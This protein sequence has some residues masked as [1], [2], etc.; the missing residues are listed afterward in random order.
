MLKK[1]YI[2]FGI[3]CALLLSGC[4]NEEIKKG[5]TISVAPVIEKTKNLDYY[6]KYKDS[7]NVC[8]IAQQDD[9]EYFAIATSL[10]ICPSEEN[11]NEHGLKYKKTM[12]EYRP[13]NIDGSCGFAHLIHGENKV[14]QQELASLQE[15]LGDLDNIEIHA[16][17]KCPTISELSNTIVKDT[18]LRFTY[19]Y[20]NINT[21]NYQ[22]IN[23]DEFRNVVS[24]DFLSNEDVS[25]I[26]D[27]GNTEDGE[28]NLIPKILETNTAKD[29]CSGDFKN[30]V[31]D[32]EDFKITNIYNHQEYFITTNNGYKLP[33]FMVTKGAFSVCEGD[34]TR[35]DFYPNEEILNQGY[36]ENI[37]THMKY[38]SPMPINIEEK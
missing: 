7:N 18:D 11:L 30:C 33:K 25:L 1:K 14:T 13:S 20:M 2:P 16:E 31:Y 27:K 22:T 5:A 37:Y 19:N 8:G 10:D 36:L 4:S 9:G 26:T 34:F 15:K 35:C 3:L 32:S 28:G 38:N 23:F 6:P 12:D 17:K 21:E 24:V 29:I